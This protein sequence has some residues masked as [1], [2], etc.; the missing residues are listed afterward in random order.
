MKEILLTNGHKA[1][2]DDDDFYELSKFKWYYG[3]G[4][5]VRGV[6]TPKGKRNISMHRQI[7]N[8]VPFGRKPTID[9]INHDKLDNRKSNLRICTNQENCFNQSKTHGKAKYK[10]VIVATN[11]KFIAKIKYNYKTYSLGRYKKE[12]DA[13]IAYNNKAK[14]LFGEY[15]LLNLIPDANGIKA[16]GGAVGEFTEAMVKKGL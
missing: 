12:E 10:G 4:Y 11:G 13:A 16:T 2:V 14:E 6:Q 3:K 9:H 5:A 15:A 8:V 1:I 7:L